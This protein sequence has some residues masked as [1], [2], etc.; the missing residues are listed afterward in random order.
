MIEDFRIRDGEQLF[1]LLKENFPEEDRAYGIRPDAWGEVLRRIHRPPI[2]LVVALARLARRPIYRFFT[3]RDDG[4]LVATSLVSFAPRIGYISMVMVDASH[5]RR[6][7]AR[8]LLHR[9]HEEIARFHRPNAVLDVLSQNRSARALYDSEGYR[10]LRTATL[11]TRSMTDPGPASGASPAGTVRPY[12]KKDRPELARILP[13]AGRRLN[14]SPTIDQVLGSD[15]ASWVLEERGRPVAWI[16]ATSSEFMDAAGLATPIVDPT[17]DPA[18]VAALLDTATRWCQAHHAG[19]AICRVPNDL[20]ASV[21][22]ITER[23]FTSTL[24]ADTLYRPL[25]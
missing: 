20:S 9:C 11:Y 25:R 16:S 22:A 18:G 19:W 4:R 23:G 3:I 2:R 8:R 24:T 7:Y 17:A 10:L 15:S 6:G 5:R 14:A 21:R 12:A 13:P 1:A